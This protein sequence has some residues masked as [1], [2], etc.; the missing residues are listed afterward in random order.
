M[1]MPADEQTRAPADASDGYLGRQVGNYRI[2][3]KIA[4]GG[5]GVVYRAAHVRLGG[6]VALKILRPE[7]TGTGSEPTRFINEARAINEIGHHNIVR[8]LDFIEEGDPPVVCMAM[9]L[10]E[11]ETLGTRI[12]RNVLEPEEAI[13][14]ALQ[15]ADALM[16]THAR[17]LLHRDLKPENVF[18]VPREGTYGELI[19]PAV[20]LLDFGVAKG[21]GDRRV[22]LTNPETVLGTPEYLSPEQIRGIPLG[23]G[24][25]IYGLGLLL[26][27]M[28]AGAPPFR[29]LNLGETVLQQVANPP[30]PISSKRPVG[31]GPVPA[32]LEALVLRCLAKEPEERFA[33]ARAL[34]DAL[35]ALLDGLTAG[36]SR[37]SLQEVVPA[38][39]APAALPP[40]PRR[41]P[42][43]LALAAVL[44]LGGGVVLLW[45]RSPRSRRPATP[46]VTVRSAPVT[47]PSPAAV[48]RPSAASRPAAPATPVVV[49]ALPPS[50]V[51][52]VPPTRPAKTTKKTPRKPVH[53]RA[54]RRRPGQRKGRPHA[55]PAGKQPA[56]NLSSGGTLDPFTR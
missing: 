6:E 17:Q 52:T 46:I 2:V 1:T 9:E 49:Q 45:K 51:P 14:V 54:L 28:L 48:P 34:Q 50:T 16:A 39:A 7:L 19:A 11:G 13:D 8:V 3:D 41:W 47:R 56:T 42:V 21:F 37:P 25:D 12:Y 53:K 5:M 15:I 31:A 43:A 27:E 18:L 40:A 55:R 44:V 26:Y 35:R 20:K 36:S 10:L 22:D 4:A 23:P 32:E 38:P 33:D 24:C 30:P 29:G